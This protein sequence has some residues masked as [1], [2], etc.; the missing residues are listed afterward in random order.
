MILKTLKI[1]GFRL[2]FIVTLKQL[3]LWQK[4]LLQ[5]LKISFLK[6]QSKNNTLRQFLKQKTELFLSIYNSKKG[7]VKN[8]TLGLTAAICE[9]L[10]VASLIL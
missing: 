6:L 3:K 8:Y 4:K 5:K 10:F 7:S 1:K 2:K 9:V